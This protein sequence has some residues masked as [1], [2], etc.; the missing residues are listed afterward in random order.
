MKT[1]VDD[2]QFLLTLTRPKRAGIVRAV[3][4]FMLGH[5]ADII[6]NRQFGDRR[7]GRSF[8]RMRSATGPHASLDA[9]RADF[10]R[11]NVC[12]AAPREAS[13]DRPVSCPPAGL[14]A[15]PP[16][17]PGPPSRCLP[18]ERHERREDCE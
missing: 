10:L 7:T 15:D 6:D 16:R 14:A 1:R 9:L 17:R 8:M 4:R 2:R 13:E 11:A 5:G 3:S 12:E 18:D